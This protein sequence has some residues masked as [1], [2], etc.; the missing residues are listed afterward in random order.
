[1]MNAKQP[2]K[3]GYSYKKVEPAGN[4]PPEERAATHRY[5]LSGLAWR[6][7]PLYELA[8]CPFGNSHAGLLLW[9][10]FGRRTYNN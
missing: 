10:D 8:G 2:S 3:Y 5:K 9:V 4:R 1:M 6:I 7:Q